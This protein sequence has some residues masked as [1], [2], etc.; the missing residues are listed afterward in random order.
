MKPLSTEAED[1]K[2]LQELG[3]ASVQVIHDLK[4]QFNGL[5]LYATFLRKRIERN[6]RPADEYETIIKLIA[7]IERAASDLATLV[8]Y[9]RELNIQSQPRVDLARVLSMALT[10][11]KHLVEISADS[12]EGRFD[13][14]A[15]SE[16]FKDIATIM[17]PPGAG[18]TSFLKVHLRRDEGDNDDKRALAVI[19]WHGV[20]GATGVQRKFPPSGAN[21]VRMALA[22][23]TI[24]AH[25]GAVEYIPDGLRTRLPLVLSE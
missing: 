11:N 23:R 14:S 15:L 2:A 20:E 4:N 12:Y 1:T 9:G 25:G 22:A 3:R 7:G 13:I 5:K 8:R 17:C 21:G 18:T 16:A 10:E 24:E 6:E 19:E